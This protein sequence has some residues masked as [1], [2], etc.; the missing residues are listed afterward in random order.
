MCTAF[1]GTRNAIQCK[2]SDELEMSPA[3]ERKIVQCVTHLSWRWRS[4]TAILFHLTSAIVFQ[5]SA[6][7]NRTEPNQTKNAYEQICT[8]NLFNYMLYLYN[9]YVNDGKSSIS[10]FISHLDRFFLFCLLHFSILILVWQSDLLADLWILF[11]NMHAYFSLVSF[12]RVAVLM[13]IL[14]LALQIHDW[15]RGFR[16]T[17]TLSCV[18]IHCSVVFHL[19]NRFQQKDI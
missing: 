11:C 7:L 10:I 2:L 19:K 4:A 1:D 18:Q 3:N 17:R 6:K 5:S 13:T 9:Y 16:S 14:V 12:Q 15:K 8:T